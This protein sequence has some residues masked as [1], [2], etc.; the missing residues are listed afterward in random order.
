MPPPTA[1]DVGGRRPR[2][3]AAA[4][5]HRSLP[6]PHRPAAADSQGRRRPPRPPPAAR[7]RRRPTVAG[8]AAGAAPPRRRRRRRRSAISRSRDAAAR[9]RHRPSSTR[10]V[11]RKDDR[12]GG[13]GVL[14][15]AQYA[16]LW[17]DDG[18]LERARQGGDR[19]ICAC[20]D[21]DGLD[22]ADYPTP[23]F[24][25][26]AEPAALAEAEL[27]LTARVLTFARHAQ[28]G[29]VHFSRVSGD[30]IYDQV[31]PEPADVLA[32][33]R[34]RQRRRRRRSTAISRRMPAT[35]R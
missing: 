24:K 8:A 1:A 33:A 11:D 27:R 22:P 34:G 12:T 17:V 9:T 32:Q 14:P 19:A 15:D 23:R 5:R 6:E 35:R 13:R 30:I 25:A 10:F 16:P 26:G 3:P 7:R 21:A 28:I 4:E 18:A 20:V 31:A 2:R 29:R